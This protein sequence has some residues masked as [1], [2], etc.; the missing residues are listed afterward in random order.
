LLIA[1]AGISKSFLATFKETSLAFSFDIAGLFAGFLIATQ[2][3][4]FRTPWAIALY[5]AIISAKVMSGLLSGRLSTALHLG[6]VYPRFSGNTKSF[7]KLIEA[8][9][10]LTLSVSL[11]VSVISFLLGYLF[12]GITLADFSSILLVMISTMAIG[13]LFVFITAKL[14]FLTFKRGLDPDIIVYPIMSTALSIFITL[15]FI[16][17]LNL[18]FSGIMGEVTLAI[19]AFFHVFLALYLLPKNWRELEFTKTIKE[20]I[21]MMLFVAFILTITGVVFKNITDFALDRKE[22]Y[23]IYPALIN[24]VSDVG[25]VVGSTANTKLA[26]GLLTPSFSSIRHHAKNIFSAWASSLILF[27]VLAVISLAI[28]QIFSYT[29]YSSF[30]LLILIS[31]LIAVAVIV[32]VSY[33]VSI[34]TF[35]RGL[36]PDNF[37]IPIESSLATIVTSIALLLALL[38]IM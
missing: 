21:V 2:L 4:V 16:G 28:N 33:A 32:L 9:I 38:L 27:T 19:I 37:V 5:P 30:I 31:N 35:K 6:V 10:V 12:L 1:H 14:A 25:S 29:T 20:S 13:L 15:C 3:G 26:L 23:T 24:M 36:D 34:L 7:Y 18:F 17:V 8:I 22:I 11:L